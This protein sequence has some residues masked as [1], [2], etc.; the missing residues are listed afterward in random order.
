FCYTVLLIRFWT[1]SRREGAFI[2]LSEE[3]KKSEPFSY[4]EKVRIFYFSGS[5]PGR[6][7]YGLGTA[8]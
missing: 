1:H 5:P 6:H 4:R 3:N 8:H 7:S 2:L